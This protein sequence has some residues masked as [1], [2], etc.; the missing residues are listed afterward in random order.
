[1]ADATEDEVSAV[2]EHVSDTN[3]SIDDALQ[4]GADFFKDIKSRTIFGY[5]TSR[6]GWVE[7]LG[8]SEHIGMEKWTGCQHPDGTHE[9]KPL[10]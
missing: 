7:E 3:A 9:P 1:L 8:R 2:L 5:Y 10:K 4:P 6:E